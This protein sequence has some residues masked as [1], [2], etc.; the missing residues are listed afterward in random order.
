MKLPNIDDINPSSEDYI[1]QVEKGMR[2]IDQE[3][4]RA[5]EAIT[6]FNERG[7]DELVTIASESVEVPG[8]ILS[9]KEGSGILLDSE[10]KAFFIALGVDVQ[11]YRSFQSLSVEEKIRMEDIRELL[12]KKVKEEARAVSTDYVEADQAR[13]HFM[14]AIVGSSTITNLFEPDNTH[15]DARVYVVENDKVYEADLRFEA[16]RKGQL[17]ESPKP[18][19]YLVQAD[20][21]AEVVKADHQGLNAYLVR[22]PSALFGKQAMF[23]YAANK[24]MEDYIN[25]HPDFAIRQG[26]EQFMDYIN[27]MIREKT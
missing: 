4:A 17:I 21:I 12:F 23:D 18:L 25:T 6:D 10:H 14:N 15:A 20:E 26:I 13:I 9:K 7:I 24:L 8:I 27:E 19:A 5:Q 2:T 22:N 1:T 3:L 11:M 16:K